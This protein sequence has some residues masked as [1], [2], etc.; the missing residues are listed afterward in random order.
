MIEVAVD[1][2]GADNPPSE[3]IS[4]VFDAL[5]DN[6]DL[7]V[8]VCGDKAA[9]EQAVSGKA[10]DKKRL[11]VIDAPQTILNTDNP[12]D[13]V[14]GKKD[15]SLVSAVELCRAGKAKAL[16]TCGATGAIFVAAMLMLKKIADCPALLC[17]PRKIDG[18]PFCIVDCGANV[19]CRAEKL[20]SFAKLG[21]AYMKAIGTEKPKVVLLNN[22]AEDKKGSALT[23][24]ANEL[25]RA[26]SVD[27]IGN[28]EGTQ[29]LT[30]E[31][32]V[33]VCEGF[34]GN[35]L[36]KTMEGVALGV[37]K[38]I[39]TAMNKLGIDSDGY[40]KLHDKLYKKYNYTE[41]DGAVLLG[42]S[43]PIIKGHGAATAETVYHIIKSAYI[44]A[45]NDISEKIR[46]EI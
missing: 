9:I 31:G 27:F 28:L 1:I 13:A 23:K 16:V 4:G 38:E 30:G 32:D 6:K 43:A 8:Y 45:R 25:L 2:Q 41:L 34:S 46:Q 26:S 44:L 17:E 36:L 10:Y 14:N 42:F 12:V 37:L 7:F 15:S 39:D 40:K 22:G 18:T 35:I 3:L 19:D 21:C 20:V 11:A 33:V 29:I 5:N 24:K